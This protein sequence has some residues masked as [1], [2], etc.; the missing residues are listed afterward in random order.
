MPTKTGLQLISSDDPRGQQYINS[1]SQMSD[2]IVTISRKLYFVVPKGED[3]RLYTDIDVYNSSFFP[4]KFSALAEDARFWFTGNASISRDIADSHYFTADLQYQC[5]SSGSY[6]YSSEGDEADT[7]IDGRKIDADTKPWK[8]RPTEINFS[9]QSRQVPMTAA[10]TQDAKKYRDSD[11]ISDEKY[12]ELLEKYGEGGVE[13]GVFPP[14]TVKPSVPI[15]NSAGDRILYQEEKNCLQM[16]FTYN[17][18]YTK[19]NK[20]HILDYGNTVNSAGLTV[21]GFKIKKGTALLRPP[22]ATLVKT[23]K[24]G[25]NKVKWKYWRISVSLLIDPTREVFYARMLNVGDRAM[26]GEESINEEDG[27]ELVNYICAKSSSIV[28][29]TLPKYGKKF[30]KSRICKIRLSKY[31]TTEN[32][33][34][35]YVPTGKEKIISWDF[36]LAL[37]HWF[38]SYTGAHIGKDGKSVN[39]TGIQRYDLQCEQLTQIPLRGLEFYKDHTESEKG[40]EVYGGV[41]E[42]AIEK[43]DYHYLDFLKYPSMN[44]AGL[45]LPAK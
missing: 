29:P 43:K 39:D 4:D 35:V 38:F 18:E 6:D 21:C 17:V 25:T 13:A 41:D 9:T 44:W 36:Y 30:L 34:R 19:W 26:W 33:L 2:G 5:G 28:G 15:V 8:L 42:D 27:D 24:P 10:W 23:L 32:G 11:T 3:P 20:S 31:A 16:S 40:T 22:S 12:K 14:R 37:R 1:G 45:N 7:D